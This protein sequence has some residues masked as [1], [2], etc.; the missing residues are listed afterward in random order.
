MRPAHCAVFVACATHEVWAADYQ[1]QALR[2]ANAK[3]PIAQVA[4]LFRASAFLDGAKDGWNRWQNVGIA[5]MQ[6]AASENAE[7]NAVWS[8]AAFEIARRL[9][10]LGARPI[11]QENVRLLCDQQPVARALVDGSELDYWRSSVVHTASSAGEGAIT[12]AKAGNEPEALL[13]LW[14]VCPNTAA[15]PHQSC[16]PRSKPRSKLA[17]TRTVAHT[18]SRHT[19]VPRPH[20]GRRFATQA[21]P[22]PRSG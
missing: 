20:Y 21:A 9:D 10:P 3:A 12:I 14:Q 11:I 2:T 1:A 8:L 6:Q 17:L 19:C 7:R 13:L 15:T 16:P 22:S 18:A 4:S 5:L